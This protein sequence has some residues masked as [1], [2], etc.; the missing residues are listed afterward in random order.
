MSALSVSFAPRAVLR[1][2]FPFEWC[3]LG[4][5]LLL[6]VLW[7][8]LVGLHIGL[9]WRDG[10]VLAGAATVMLALRGLAI[11]RGGLMAEYLALTVAATAVFGVLSYLCCMHAAPLADSV[12]QRVDVALGFDWLHWFGVVHAY[13]PAALALRFCYDSL[14]Y[15]GLYFGLLLALLD[16]KP[17]L[18]EMF[19]LVF[20]AGFFTSAGA[21]LWPAL[22]PF[23]QFG[24]DSHGDFIP[25]IEHL[26]SGRELT[27]ALH[28][29][30]G[31]VSFPSFHTTMALAYAY[32]F[33]HTGAIGVAV[34]ALNCGM[35][36]AIPVFGGHYLTD[37]FAGAAV[38][39]ASLGIVRAW[40]RLVRALRA[41]PADAA[42][43]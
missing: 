20:V 25:V 41:A 1:S 33:R 32:G 22:G 31:V 36:C 42:P 24:M 14:V 37:M 39:L 16:R 29:M 10:I 40:P 4:A 2:E 13:P 21:F 28:S 7:S 38:M 5:V 19:W 35:L 34:A 30:T 3:G 15:Q 12:F 26:R 43:G 8:P 18:S 17:A 23:R 6:D 11:R 9:V 27:F